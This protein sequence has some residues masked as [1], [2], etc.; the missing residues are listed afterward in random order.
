MNHNQAPP[1]SRPHRHWPAAL[2]IAALLAFA[3][4]VAWQLRPTPV[5]NIPATVKRPAPA[6]PDS[7]LI[8]SESRVAEPA[9][10][11][12]SPPAPPASPPPPSAPVTVE[13]ETDQ[14][15]DANHGLIPLEGDDLH[16]DDLHGDPPATVESPEFQHLWLERI[17]E[18][19]DTGE[20]DVARESLREYRRRYPF[21]SLPDDLDGLLDE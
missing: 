10:V 8:A 15:A 13:L 4:G 6:A 7:P 1:D 11:R 2:G 9:Q 14:A 18:Q 16:L 12:D 5:G 21:Q 3:V 17:R 20:L 19:R